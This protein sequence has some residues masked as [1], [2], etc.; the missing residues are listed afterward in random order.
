M[1]IRDVKW[2]IAEEQK[3]ENRALERLGDHAVWMINS[4]REPKDRIVRAQLVRF[5][6]DKQE[7]QD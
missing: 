6:T 5:G 4:I 3:R 2:R 1:S 7:S